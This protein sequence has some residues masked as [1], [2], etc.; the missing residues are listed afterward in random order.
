MNG[1]SICI[2]N[3]KIPSSADTCGAAGFEEGKGNCPGGGRGGGAAAFAVAG[4]QGG[5]TCSLCS[6]WVAEGGGGRGPAAFAVAWRGARQPLQ[7]LGR[8]SF[9]TL[10][11]VE[12][13]IFLRLQ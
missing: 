13:F 10:Q 11:G 4:R 8:G 6:S 7:V 12:D 5:R 1:H 9:M 2:M 3:G